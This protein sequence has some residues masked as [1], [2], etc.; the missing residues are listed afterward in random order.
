MENILHPWSPSDLLIIKEHE[1]YCTELSRCLAFLKQ[2]G[3][4]GSVVPK[5]PKRKLNSLFPQH[6]KASLEFTCESLHGYLVKNIVENIPDNF[7][8]PSI[9][10]LQTV[11]ELNDIIPTLKTGH[12]FV[13]KANSVNITA[14][15]E[16]GEWLN[17]AFQLHKKAIITNKI[18]E[19][20]SKWLSEH[21]GL[22]ER[23]ARKLREMS[24]LLKKYPMFK[25]IGISFSELYDIRKKVEIML[26]TN[27][28]IKINRRFG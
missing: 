15:L 24:I 16:Y 27:K 12:L 8:Y 17:L 14:F 22:N 5:K 21:V 26:E 7:T 1:Q 20:W 11:P 19:P 13:Q 23:Y 3:P 2:Y 6:K 25:K 18:S 9:R 28:Q 10:D 4:I